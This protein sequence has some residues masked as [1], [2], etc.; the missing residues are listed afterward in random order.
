MLGLGAYHR[1]GVIG[2]ADCTF[3]HELQI[4][5]AVTH[6]D[7]LLTC[8]AEFVA[9]FKQ[10]A[11]FD[12]G[13]DDFAE[14]AELGFD[15]RQDIPHLGR[16]LFDSQSPETQPKAVE[17][18]G[19]RGRSGDNDTEIVLKCFHHARNA[20]DLGK[21]S[22]G[23]QEQDGKVSRVRGADVLVLDFLG[24]QAHRG[25]EARHGL[26]YSLFVGR[27]VGVNE[28]LVV[29]H[30]VLRVNGQPNRV[31]RTL[32]RHFDGV[33]DQFIAAWN[34]LDVGVELLGGQQALDDGTQLNFTPG[35]AGTDIGHHALQITDTAGQTLHLTQARVDLLQ[36]FTNQLE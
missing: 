29:L 26:L 23:W 22:F 25:L 1:L 10:G 14:L 27:L 30:R 4:V 20:A 33:L 34:G 28:A 24:L 11:A 8:D 9:A 3:A 18:G 21:Q 16:P 13:I 6:A 36:S 32:A 17:H 15:G 35:T 31:F 7:D 12:F 5:R 2:D 19:Q